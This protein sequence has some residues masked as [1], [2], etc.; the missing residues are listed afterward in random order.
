[1]VGLKIL[2][3]YFVAIAIA[4]TLPCKLETGELFTLTEGTKWKTDACDSGAEC[5]T[6]CETGYTGA[7][8]TYK[9]EPAFEYENKSKKDNE[10]NEV[11]QINPP[12]QQAWCVKKAERGKFPFRVEFINSMQPATTYASDCGAALIAPSWILAAGH[13]YPGRATSVFTKDEEDL[14]SGVNPIKTYIVLGG[15]RAGYDPALKNEGPAPAVED[16][17]NCFDPAKRADS[18]PTVRRVSKRYTISWKTIKNQGALFKKMYP[19]QEIGSFFYHDLALYKLETPITE[20]EFKSEDY[21]PINVTDVIKEKGCDLIF[22]VFRWD[23]HVNITNNK[24]G[25]PW[26]PISDTLQPVTVHVNPHRTS[27]YVNEGWFSKLDQMWLSRTKQLCTEQTADDWKKLDPS[28]TYTNN[29][30]LPEML[31]L[32]DTLCSRFSDKENCFDLVSS[33]SNEYCARDSGSPGLLRFIDAED[34]AH[35]AHSS[36]VSTGWGSCGEFDLE[37]FTYTPVYAQKFLEIMGAD[38][39]TVKI[40]ILK[41]CTHGEICEY[42]QATCKETVDKIFAVSGEH[43]TKGYFNVKRPSSS[44]CISIFALFVAM[45]IFFL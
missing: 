12:Q 8:F 24:S 34:K 17:A 35:Y 28:F 27:K 37:Q 6:E 9:C 30:C 19:R 1:M 23:K 32:D 43:A 38:A 16:I 2:L 10:G 7:D 36:S 13:C 5:K 15:K 11:S 39:D 41:D 42:G 21:L 14:L 3:L 29:K 25:R 31:R 33:M 45:V 4:A 22:P 20:S 44:K 26:Q 18:C 40:A